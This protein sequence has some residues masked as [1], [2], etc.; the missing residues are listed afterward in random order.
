M[1]HQKQ[2]YGE[3]SQTHLQGLSETPE[4][5]ALVIVDIQD[6]F[7]LSSHNMKTPRNSEID[8][9][10]TQIA[11]LARAFHKAGITVYAVYDERD[12]AFNPALHAPDF[13][14][15]DSRYI[16]ITVR[17]NDES[18]F[19]GSPIDTLLRDNGH[20]N[21]LICGVWLS[22]CV[23]KS[24]FDALYNGYDTTLISDSVADQTPEATMHSYNNIDSKIVPHMGGKISTSQ[25][26]LRHASLRLNQP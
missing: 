24:C 17:K 14:R 4:R 1:K 15:L 8:Q 5:A 7:C 16:D 2:T 26:V 12:P 19:K 10:T 25:Q 9:V 3:C 22:R 18:V 23:R 11:S 6:R 21:L 13:Y 20:N